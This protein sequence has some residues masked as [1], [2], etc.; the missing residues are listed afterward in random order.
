MYGGKLRGAANIFYDYDSGKWTYGLLEYADAYKQAVEFLNVCY[1]NGY[2]HPD[3][4]SME[5]EKFVSTYTSGNALFLRHYI[6]Q[7]PSY[8]EAGINAKVI[9]TPVVEG[10]K[11]Y[12]D[13][14]YQSDSSGWYHIVNKDTKYPELCAEILDFVSSEEFT[15]AFYWGFEGETFEVDANG[16]RSFLDSFMQLSSDEKIAKYGVGSSWNISNLVNFCYDSYLE[17]MATRVDPIDREGY[18]LISGGLNNGTIRTNID[19]KAPD[20]DTSTQEENSLITTACATY[21]SESLAK[22]VL[23]E[24]D[25][26][27]WDSFVNGLSTVGDI[28]KVLDAYN[29][30]EQKPLRA[31]QEDR[32]YFQP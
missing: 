11:P 9:V 8:S 6:S 14:A 29:N 23:G 5:W 3:F 1:K 10:E 13:T 18:S 16:K 15:E 25:I 31:Q 17:S 22:F 27:E 7:G 20:F 30:A 24:R 19:A 4:L 12:A 2:I 26:S 32:N 28:N 21:I